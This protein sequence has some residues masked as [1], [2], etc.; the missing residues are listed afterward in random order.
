MPG[1]LPMR[2]GYGLRTA[3]W[4]LRRGRPRPGVPPRHLDFQSN[5]H[6]PTD[7]T[8]LWDCAEKMA[9]ER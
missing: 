9:P 6:E 4:R 3:P 1:V 5:I 2:R 8:L 7:S